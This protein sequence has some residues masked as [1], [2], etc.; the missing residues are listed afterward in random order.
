MS[1]KITYTVYALYSPKFEKIYI[2]YTS[3][4]DNR[5]KSHNHLANKGYTVKF[6]PWIVVHAEEYNSKKE[7]IIR[8][9]SLK[10]AKGR[11]FVWDKIHQLADNNRAQ[12]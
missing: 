5:L 1:E 10:S 12:D 3:D 7:A 11:R 9:K 8:E 2:G 6:R 4:L